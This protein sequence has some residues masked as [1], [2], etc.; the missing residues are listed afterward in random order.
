MDIVSTRGKSL[1]V[2]YH[3][4]RLRDYGILKFVINLTVPVDS[5]NCLDWTLYDEISGHDKHVMQSL[6]IGW[7]LGTLL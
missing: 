7:M 4:G 5:S 2:M 1:L 6:L 3:Q